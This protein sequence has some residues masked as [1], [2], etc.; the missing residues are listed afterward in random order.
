MSNGKS[1]DLI[2]DGVDLLDATQRYL[3][4]RRGDSEPTRGEHMVE[5]AGRRRGDRD[6][7]VEIGDFFSLHAYLNGFIDKARISGEAL[8]PAEFLPLYPVPND[9]ASWSEI[10]RLYR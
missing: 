5:S 3:G 7:G 4:I 8:T 1:Q 9:G 2:D 10:K 6:G